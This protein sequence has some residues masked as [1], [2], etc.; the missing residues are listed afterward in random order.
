MLSEFITTVGKS[1]DKVDKRNSYQISQN[2][3]KIL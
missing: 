3:L 2:N 1:Y